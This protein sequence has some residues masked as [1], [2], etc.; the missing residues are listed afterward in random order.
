MGAAEPNERFLRACRGLPVD[1]TPIWLMRQAGRYMPE[2]LALRSR[3][4]MLE[5]INQPELSAEITLQP[6]DAFGVDAA[7]I[8]SDI[9][10]PLVGMGLKLE[11]LKG[12]GPYI[13]NPIDG[14]AAVD[15]LRTPSAEELMPGTLKAIEIVA[16]ELGPRGV[17][18]IGFAGAPFTLACYA[19]EGGGSNSYEK[20]RAFMY[21]EP[22][23]WD[24]LMTKLTE[25]Q[26][27]YLV[28][29]AKSGAD[30]LQVFDSWAG[31]VHGARGYEKFVAPYNKMLFQRLVKTGVPVINFSTGTGAYIES[32]AAC[33]GDVVGVDWRLS[34]DEAWKRIGTDR[35]IQGNLDPAALL[36]CWEVLKLEADDVI[37]RVSSRPGHIFNLGHGVLKSTPVDNVRR[38]V[39]YVQEVTQRSRVEEE[40]RVRSQRIER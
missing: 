9:L 19:I 16:A 34:I 14:A 24:R 23:A 13:D 36:A 38:L 37:N 6:V 32:V 22:N 40:G 33:G 15:A 39:H 35:A 20:V 30:A 11:Y 7:I 2:Y 27:D 5:T 3:Y 12:E 28:A 17:P 21:N 8:F 1:R 10:P 18:L 31:Q 29:Q 26:A 25:V 4:T